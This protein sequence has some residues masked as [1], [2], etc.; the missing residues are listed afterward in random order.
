MQVQER[1]PLF[2]S[3]Q[4]AQAIGERLGGN[5][6]CEGCKRVSD[7]DAGKM[8]DESRFKSGMKAPGDDAKHSTFAS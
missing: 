4:D 6:D 5:K 3:E 2:H 8:L 7:L 1:Q